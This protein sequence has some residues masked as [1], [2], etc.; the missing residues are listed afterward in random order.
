MSEGVNGKQV[1]RPS[2]E[3]VVRE[4]EGELVLV[5]LTS[6]VGD[7]EAEL[8]SL[9]ETGKAI[10]G[11]LD[12]QKSVADVVSELRSVYEDPDGEIDVHVKG[13]LSELSNRGMVVDVATEA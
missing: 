6:G 5:P 4:I 11:R 9:N 3:V 2:D 7:L 10:W 1:F 13:L 8:F 12:G